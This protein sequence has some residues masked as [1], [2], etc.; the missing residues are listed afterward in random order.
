M[1]IGGDYYLVEFY[2]NN[3]FITEDILLVHWNNIERAAKKYAENEGFNYDKIK[4]HFIG[5][6]TGDEI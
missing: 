5:E 2:L 3:K 4:S 6:Q 1:N